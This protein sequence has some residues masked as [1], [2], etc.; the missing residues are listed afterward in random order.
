MSNW[1]NE[2][3]IYEYEEIIA[4]TD[5]AWLVRID[6]EDYWLPKSQ[7]EIDEDHQEIEIPNWLAKDKE[8]I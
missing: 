3:E 5:L 8:I 4:D 6:G 2:I 7:V 1:N